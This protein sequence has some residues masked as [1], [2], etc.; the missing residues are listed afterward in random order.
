MPIDFDELIGI[1]PY[2]YHVPYN[3]IPLKLQGDQGEHRRVGHQGVPSPTW[4]RR[5]DSDRVR[6][7]KPRRS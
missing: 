2:L 5:R 3:R 7:R 6:G 1:S 4:D